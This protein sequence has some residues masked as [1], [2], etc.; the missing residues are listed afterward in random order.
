MSE[1]VPLKPRAT[2]KLTRNDARSSVVEL[3]LN[4]DRLVGFL[5]QEEAVIGVMQAASILANQ[6]GWSEAKFKGVARRCLREAIRAT[7]AAHR[8]PALLVPGNDTT[9]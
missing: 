9:H 1:G 8:R 6:T 2:T 5:S 3:I 7:E 4:M